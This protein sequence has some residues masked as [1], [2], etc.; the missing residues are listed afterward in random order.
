[1]GN[2]AAAEEQFARLLQTQQQHMREI[3]EKHTSFD[4]VELTLTAVL[5]FSETTGNF[6]LATSAF[7]SMVESVEAVV[8]DKAHECILK[9]MLI[10][11]KVLSAQPDQALQAEKLLLSLSTDWRAKLRLNPADFATAKKLWQVLQAFVDYY[12]T[13][14]MRQRALEIMEEQ[15]TLRQQFIM[16]V[17]SLQTTV[18]TTAG[19]KRQYRFQQ[20]ELVACLHTLLGVYI[21]QQEFSKGEKLCAEMLALL[22]PESSADGDFSVDDANNSLRNV[23][24]PQVL[25]LHITHASLLRAVNR[26]AE[27][28]AALL[29]CLENA[30]A[31]FGKN[32]ACLL[33]II[34]NLA[35]L[36]ADRKMFTK[37]EKLSIA[38]YDQAMHLYGKDD[39]RA[40]SFGANLALL[41]TVT[42]KEEMAA[43]LFRDCADR[44]EALYGEDDNRVI[45][46][47][48][49]QERMATQNA[50]PSHCCAVC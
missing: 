25:Q 28:E 43:E 3:L 21:N 37:A 12:E 35:N 48:E 45:Q 50:A 17:G 31:L 23:Y 44:A 40:I 41:Y 36:Y 18:S 39:I 9:L 1:M 2:S 8:N 49:Q 38:C 30:E 5:R 20:Q 7:H 19:D 10:Y 13:Q 26:V 33:V 42:H 4:V 27:A 15:V 24:T 46:W 16:R 11:I 29:K 32:D 14:T 34:N 47:R 22:L 6:E